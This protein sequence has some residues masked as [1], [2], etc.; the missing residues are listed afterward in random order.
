MKSQPHKVAITILAAFLVF[1]LLGACAS[2]GSSKAPEGPSP[3]EQVQALVMSSL[4]MLGEGNVAGMMANYADDFTSDQGDKAAV[5][6][7]LQ[8]AADG[9]FLDGM[10]T[11][12]DALAINVDGDTATVE[13]LSIEGAFGLFDLTFDLEKRDGK[14]LIVKQTQQ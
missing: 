1:G 10:T 13:G 5:Q 4:S 6:G 12:T 2:T 8:G 14:W 11:N 7:F 3:T 9:G